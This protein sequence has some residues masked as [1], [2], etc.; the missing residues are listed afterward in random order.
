[1]LEKALIVEE[2]KRKAR[3]DSSVKMDKALY[4]RGWGSEQGKRQNHNN[5]NKRIDGKCWYCDKKGH[6]Q[7]DCRKKKQEDANKEKTAD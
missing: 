1:M 2:A 3:S 4:S 5:N 7:R 6:K